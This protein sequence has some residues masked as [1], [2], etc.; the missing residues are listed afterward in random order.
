MGPYSLNRVFRLVLNFRCIPDNFR[1]DQVK[2]AITLLIDDPREIGNY[3]LNKW[4]YFTQFN[5]ENYINFIWDGNFKS[6]KQYLYDCFP[7]FKFDRNNPIE[8]DEINLA[9]KLFY[10]KHYDRVSK[11]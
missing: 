3:V 6:A 2:S 9:F 7:K 8:V 11:M 4:K 10:K 5:F 1:I